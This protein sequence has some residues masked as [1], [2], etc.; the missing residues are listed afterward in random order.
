MADAR[1]QSADEVV[2]HPSL[3]VQGTDP[4]EDAS[5]AAELLGQ[6]EAVRAEAHGSSR[7][8]A[9]DPAPSAQAARP[10]PSDTAAEGLSTPP[11]RPS[12]VT[13][14][15]PLQ[16]ELDEVLRDYEGL[17]FDEEEPLAPLRPM[18]V[19]TIG[20]A[21]VAPGPQGFQTN[22]H[23]QRYSHPHMGAAPGNQASSR[24]G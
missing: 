13:D 6:A 5:S 4:G 12:F 3:F 9:S 20:A 15:S 16:Q 21:P 2:H 10:G 18:R 19:E 11:T 8:S 24:N 1:F 17:Q 14:K 7:V 23:V 22:L